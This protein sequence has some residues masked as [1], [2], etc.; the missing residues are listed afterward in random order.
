MD[1]KQYQ[2]PPLVLSA[3]EEQT[4]VLE[5]GSTPTI[6]LNPT[7]RA[8]GTMTFE[9]SLEYTGPALPSPTIE[10]VCSSPSAMNP[11]FCFYEVGIYQLTLRVTDLLNQSSH[12]SVSVEV[13]PYPK[14]FEAEEADL[15]QLI[16]G[17]SGVY[18]DPLASRG[19]YCLIDWSGT[20]RI[21]WSIEAPSAGTYNLYVRSQGVCCYEGRGDSLKVNNG[22]N[23][24]FPFGNTPNGQWTLF[25]PIPVTLTKGTNT[26]QIIRSWGGIRYDY[27]ELPDL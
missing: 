24:F 12:A 1:L 4:L 11:S 21:V 15:S 27:I 14:R 19:R 3:G 16:G 6:Q 20:P 26:I 18:E 7:V 23:Q 22:A 25:G 9:W 13:V 5:G 10:E 17:N 8:A 2:N